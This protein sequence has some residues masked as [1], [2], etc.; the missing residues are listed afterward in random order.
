MALFRALETTRP[1][2]A[3]LVSDSFAASVLP[4]WM[5]R[6]VTLSRFSWLGSTIARLV[7]RRWPGARTSGVARTRLIDDWVAGAVRGGAEQVVILG[8]G[9][10]SRAWRLP[11]LSG[12]PVFEVDQRA[13]SSE[14]RNQLLAGGLDPSRIVQ[15]ALD[16]D[17]DRLGETLARNGFDARRRTVV[18]WEGVTNYLTAAAVDAVLRWTGDLAAGSTLAFTYVHASVLN[19]PSGFEGAGRILAA[20]AKTGETWT[21]GIDP[22]ELRCHL[23]RMGLRLV[24][25]L[26]ADEYR[27]RYWHQADCRWRGYGFYR[28]ALAR[29]PDRATP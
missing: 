22:A 23:E 6:L 28:A 21:C 3:R 8:A 26:G 15:V 24:E 19:D 12:I 25:D 27:S 11:V 14:K 10:D 13:T 5:R 18:I 2:S 20:V 16:F 17:R 9:F 7:D 1:A 29:V 4:G